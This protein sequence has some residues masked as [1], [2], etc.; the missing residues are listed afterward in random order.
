MRALVLALTVGFVMP[1]WSVLKRLANGRDNLELTALRA[2]GLAK[3]GP[4][5]AKDVAA[6]LGTSWTSGELALTATVSMRLPG[7]C[8]IDFASADS[9]KTLSVVWANGKKR[10]EG[11]T[12]AAAQVAVDQVCALLALHSAADGESRQALERHLAALKVDARNTTLAR[13]GGGTALVIGDRSEAAASLWVYKDKFQ[14]ARIRF[15]DE[16]GTWDV[17]FIDYASQATSD[18]FP[19]VVEVLQNG[20]QRLRLTILTADGKASLDAVKF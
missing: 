8:R 11:G 1:T 10:S 12:W 20:E 4:A 9:S 7:R 6:L 18:W 13:F 17:H 5:D 3:V 2:E 14:P 15:G 19:R 16:A